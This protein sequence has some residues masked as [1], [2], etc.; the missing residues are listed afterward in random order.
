MAWYPPVRDGCGLGG[1]FGR[2][3]G[4]ASICVWAVGMAQIQGMVPWV[5]SG[6][7]SSGS[8]RAWPI[9]GGSPPSLR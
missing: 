9:P 3:S 2:M 8:G 7:G 1:G 6:A 4:P 5:A